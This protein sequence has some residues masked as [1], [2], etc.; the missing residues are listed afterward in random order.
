MSKAKHWVFTLN[1]Y[2]DDD[3]ERLGRLWIGGGADSEIERGPGNQLRRSGESAECSYIVFGEE[4]GESG[5]DHLQGY[6]CFT[7]RKTLAQAKRLLGSR[8]HL[9]V[10][11]GTPDQAAEYCKKDDSYHEFGTVP[12]GTGSRSD[13]AE[14]VAA[15]R[16]GRNLES[17]EDEWPG[18]SLRYGSAIRRRI[19]ERD[20]PRSDKPRVIV[21][22]GA[23][24]T[25]KTRRVFESHEWRDIFRYCGGKGQWFDGYCGQRVA[26]FDDF[27]GSE[28]KLS[29][30][31]QILDRYPIIVPVKGGFVQWKP[32]IIYI[33]SNKPPEEWYANAFAEHQRA[34][35]RRFDDV[36]EFTEQEE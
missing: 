2:T 8:C 32:E 33:T 15:I 26:L 30:F 6:A 10:M 20:A 5:T 24:G 28:F 4:T 14:L 27:N 34:L 17:I 13:L 3:V 16:D 19:F 22:W 9:E 36:T 1:N 12:S 21:Y 35:L 23:T 31:L 11:R 18:H 7:S 29:Y 25:G